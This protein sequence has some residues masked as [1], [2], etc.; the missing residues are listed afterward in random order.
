MRVAAAALAL[1]GSG[2]LVTGVAQA[3]T[4]MAPTQIVGGPDNV[5]VGVTVSVSA[6]DSSAAENP[7]D[8]A[9]AGA[10]GTGGP[11][12]TGSA[13]P[14]DTASDSATASATGG[15]TATATAAPSSAGG[16]ATAAPSG[17]ASATAPAAAAATG[18]AAASLVASA[19]RQSL[20]ET[21]TDD[22]VPWMLAGAATMLAGG[23]VFRFG[24][25]S[26]PQAATAAPN[27]RRRR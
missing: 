6:G 17:S 27:A 9:T 25:R 14:T 22:S 21:G 23:L 16:G 11:D 13:A 15:P 26:T 10:S 8:G 4:T 12:G 19:P 5:G 2:L 18:P 1:S 7:T 20:A 3:V 24:P